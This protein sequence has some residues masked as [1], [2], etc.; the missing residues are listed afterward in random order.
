MLEAGIEMLESEGY[1]SDGEDA[2]GA[3]N[4]L[5]T[6]AADYQRIRDAV[7]CYCDILRLEKLCKSFQLC[8]KIAQYQG[9][10]DTR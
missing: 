9:L 6:E 1:D 5:G 7:E 3:E 4:C 8:C 10:Y 2:T